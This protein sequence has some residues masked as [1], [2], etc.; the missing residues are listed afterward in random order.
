LH[1]TVAKLIEKRRCRTHAKQQIAEKLALA[2]QN[3]EQYAALADNP[4]MSPA[5]ALA[6]R[7]LAR[8]YKAA[9]KLY[10]KAL[11]YEFCR[12]PP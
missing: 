5:A 2:R 7:N 12:G 3:A 1:D 9:M 6:A 10:E 4:R 11:A 8:S